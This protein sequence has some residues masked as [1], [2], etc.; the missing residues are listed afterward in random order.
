MTKHADAVQL[1]FFKYTK[2][3]STIPD[4][5]KPKHLEQMRALASII[6]QKK[7][8]E[9]YLQI[10][11]QEDELGQLD[12]NG[13]DPSPGYKEIQNYLYRKKTFT[14]PYV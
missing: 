6:Q 12:E 9:N 5:Q 8:Q 11:N 2:D 3:L 13:E 4:K 14:G 1:E 10:Q 7:T